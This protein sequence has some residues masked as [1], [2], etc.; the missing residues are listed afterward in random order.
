MPIDQG[1]G[2][3][4]F[5]KP[6]ETTDSNSAYKMKALEDYLAM[7]LTEV[8]RQFTFWCRCNQG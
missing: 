6:M 5:G 3:D 2:I 1:E 7:L 8:S 4:Q